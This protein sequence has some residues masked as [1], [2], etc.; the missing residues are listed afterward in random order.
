MNN[1]PIDRNIRRRALWCHLSNLAVWIPPFP[2]FVI[3]PLIFCRLDAVLF[4][5]EAGKESI[6]FTAS[7]LV[8]M[9]LVFTISIAMCGAGAVDQSW[10]FGLTA[11]LL[12]MLTHIV[13]IIFGSI[14]ANRGVSYKYPF[15][16]RF[17]DN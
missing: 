4:V 1:S 5:R 7:V 13:M 2:I 9:L 8:Y 11:I 3:L 6:N 12:L 10:I 15:A 14:Q 17:L 16:I